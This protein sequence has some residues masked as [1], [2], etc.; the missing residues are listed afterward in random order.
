MRKCIITSIIF[1]VILLSL[2]GCMGLHHL[3]HANQGAT[4]HETANYMPAHGTSN[5]SGGCH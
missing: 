1:A 3:G 4:N 5:Y 2:S